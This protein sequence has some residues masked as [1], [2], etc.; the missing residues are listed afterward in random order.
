MS[1]V[2]A[3][4]DCLTSHQLLQLTQQEQA[5]LTGRI[6]P[7]FTHAVKA[8]EVKLQMVEAP[9]TTCSVQVT[10]TLPES[11]LAQAN[12]L[13]DADIAKKIMLGAQGYQLPASTT[14]SAVF[15]VAPDHLTI[16]HAD[17]LQSGALGQLRASVEMMYSLI[18][19]ARANVTPAS[20]NSQAWGAETKQAQLAACTKKNAQVANVTDACKCQVDALAQKVSEQQ[21]AYVEYVNSNPYAF[22]TGSNQGYTK[23]LQ[24]INARCA[25]LN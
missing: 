17:T 12:A 3:Y 9:A 15:A 16:A 13:L 21:M 6:P 20:Q 18:T 24:E 19:Q 25:L 23:L 10:F 2:N 7:A 5:Y 4:A 11:D 14:P 8:G 1:S 22:A